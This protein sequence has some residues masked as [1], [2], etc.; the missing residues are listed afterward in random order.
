MGCS[1]RIRRTHVACCS[2]PASIHPQSPTCLPTRTDASGNR[3]QPPRAKPGQPGSTHPAD[4]IQAVMEGRANRLAEVLDQIASQ[5]FTQ[6]Q[7]ALELEC[8]AAV[9][10]R[11]RYAR[12]HMTEPF[13]RRFAELYK[14]SMTWLLTGH[15]PA[16]SPQIPQVT[17]GVAGGT[18]C[19]PVLSAPCEGDPRHSPAWDGSTL[20]ITG[21]AAAA[22]ERAQ[23]PYVLRVGSHDTSGRFQQN[24]LVLC[25]QDTR[26]DVCL[27]LVRRRDAKIVITRQ[28]VSG[29]M[30][31]L[32]R[33][34]A[35]SESS[36][37]VGH[38]VGVI[39]SPL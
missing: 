26:T 2:S 32:S 3:T 15:G 25:S 39:W 23:S 5:G 34:K 29:Q 8:A 12:R 20:V 13:A 24:D 27:A 22:A 30:D 18:Y 6:R 36:K 9:S 33:G 10:V 1:R 11:L 16:E 17:P 21:A 7:V 31:H 35:R 28:D 19:L 14:L 38:C 37:A 4:D